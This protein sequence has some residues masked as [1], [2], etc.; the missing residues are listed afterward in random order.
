MQCNQEP[1]SD[2]KKMQNLNANICI[3]IF[4]HF[5]LGKLGTGNACHVRQILQAPPVSN[6]PHIVCKDRFSL[7]TSLGS[8]QCLLSRTPA[9]R[10]KTESEKQRT[11]WIGLF[12]SGSNNSRNFQKDTEVPDTN[13]CQCIKN[14]LLIIFRKKC[15]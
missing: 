3:F 2:E 13:S 7:E 5:L 1:E 9:F 12:F 14:I 10:D 4:K 6:N 11:V 15:C 8:F